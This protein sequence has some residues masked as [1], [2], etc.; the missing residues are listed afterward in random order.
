ML[1]GARSDPRLALEPRFVLLQPQLPPQPCHLR[2]GGGAPHF[3]VARRGRGVAR[4]GVWIE[5]R[6]LAPACVDAAHLAAAPIPAAAV[7]SSAAVNAGDWTDPLPPLRR[8]I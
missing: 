4:P 8:W 6:A 5:D 1:P 3:A 7:L 2:R